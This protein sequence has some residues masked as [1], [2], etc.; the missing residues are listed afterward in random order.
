MEENKLI[1]FKTKW[2]KTKQIKKTKQNKTKNN[3]NKSTT[4]T[5]SK[6]V[7]DFVFAKYFKSFVYDGKPE[8]GMNRLTHKNV[9]LISFMYAFYEE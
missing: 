4:T 2:K 8:L 1:N 9:T 6:V 5:S 7:F 3:N